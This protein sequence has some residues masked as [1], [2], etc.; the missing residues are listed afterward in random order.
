M[1]NYTPED[2]KKKAIIKI[3]ISIIALLIVS[4]IGIIIRVS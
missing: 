4:I 1:D 2:E 3:V